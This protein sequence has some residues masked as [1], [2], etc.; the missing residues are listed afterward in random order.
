MSRARPAHRSFAVA[1]A[2]LL[3]ALVAIPVQAASPGASTSTLRHGGAA[4]DQPTGDDP[5]RLIVTFKPG[6]TPASRKTA[7]Q[8][9]GARQTTALPKTRSVAVHAPAGRGKEVAATLRAD[10]HE[11]AMHHEGARP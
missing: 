11:R 4:W 2:V 6:T 7:M 8:T 9:S 1:A 10:P 5:S 3:T